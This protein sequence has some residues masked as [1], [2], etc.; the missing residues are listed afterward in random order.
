MPELEMGPRQTAKWGPP[1]SGYPFHLRRGG[2]PKSPLS[3]TPGAGTPMVSSPVYHTL[4]RH[5]IRTRE[6]IGRQ[7][8][9]FTFDG[10]VVMA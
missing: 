4:N 10:L 9:A 6:T 5:G 3:T 7:C 2:T 1:P 8:D